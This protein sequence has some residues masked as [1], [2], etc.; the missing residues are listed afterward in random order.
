M[1]RQAETEGSEVASAGKATPE[2]TVV[3]V[4][5]QGLSGVAASWGPKPAATAPLSRRGA[6]KRE[7]LGVIQILKPALLLGR[8]LGKDKAGVS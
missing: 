8:T 2:V 4:P 7:G 1:L 6:A 5:R 3:R